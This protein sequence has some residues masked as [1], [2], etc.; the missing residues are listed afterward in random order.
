[1]SEGLAKGPASVDTAHVHKMI[2]EQ[3]RRGGENESRG[4]SE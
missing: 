1:M 4:G 3:V 2:D